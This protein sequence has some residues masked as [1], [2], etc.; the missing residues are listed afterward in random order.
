S[1]KL[2]RIIVKQF[3]ESYKQSHLGGRCPAYDGGKSLYTAGALPFESKEFLV[4]HFEA[5]QETIQALDVVLRAKPS[6]NYTVYFREKYNIVLKYA[7]L[8]A[9]Q[10]GSEAKPVYMPME[11]CQIVEG[12]RYTKKL[13]DQQVKAL[14]KATCRRPRDRERDIKR[15]VN[16]NNFNG[17]ECVN[18]FGIQVGQELAFVDARVGGRNTVLNDAIERKIPLVT[19]L[20]TIIFGADVTHPKPGEDSSPSIAAVI[21]W[22]QVVGSMDW[23]EVTK[24]RGIVSAQAHREEI[25]Q[26]LY[27][28]VQDPQKGVVHSGMIRELLMAFYK[29]TGQKPSRIIFYR[30][31]VS[32]GQFSQVL[33]YEMDAIRK[34]CKVYSVV[35]PAYYAH[36]AAFRARYYIED[37]TSDSGSTDVRRSARDR[38]VEVR[39]LPSIRENVKEVMFY[40]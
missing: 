14:L 8:P 20:P 29:S 35:P 36:L 4:R 3:T 28:I 18:D 5:P 27:K 7:S 40:C 30:D 31:G 25:I 6:E 10:S 23:P 26:D 38:N 17:E 12:Q 37:E 2:N 32:E 19:D 15:M 24:Y 1:K 9:L 34:V 13:N 21:D 22:L 33:L 16:N 39:P 11:L